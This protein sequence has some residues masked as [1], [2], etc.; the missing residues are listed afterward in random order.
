MTLERGYQ[1]NHGVTTEGP[2][3]F[4]MPV[5]ER[6]SK[7]RQELT[8]AKQLL[9]EGNRREYQRLG[10]QIYEKLRET[11]ERAVEEVLLNSTVLRFGDSVQ[12]NR[13]AKL[14]D[15]TDVDI[16]I[17]TREMSRCS[18]FVHDEAGVLHTDV[19]DPDIVE[20]DINRLADWVR[21]LRRDR[22]RS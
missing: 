19:P 14:T 18:N 1:H 3:W 20:E 22:G 10:D 16:E 11:W 13:L 8:A 4:T 17:V 7:L 2:P 9:K 5:R 15:I 12:T 6:V 21:R